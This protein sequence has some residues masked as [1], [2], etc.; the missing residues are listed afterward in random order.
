MADEWVFGEEDADDAEVVEPQERRP[1]IDFTIVGHR[2]D[3]GKKASAKF[4]VRGES[5]QGS[6]LRMLA[7]ADTR[8]NVDTSAVAHWIQM[9]LIPE[10]WDRWYTFLDE[11]DVH[12][13]A[14]ASLSRNLL[15]HYGQRPTAPRRARRA[16]PR[17]A[18]KT[19]TVAHSGRTSTS[20]RSRSATRST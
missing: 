20:N 3:D 12:S 18:G 2:L 4:T 11:V 9:C 17:R 5:P 7:S 10:D 15:E 8:G 16:T 6:T 14:M 1:D 19:S 13:T